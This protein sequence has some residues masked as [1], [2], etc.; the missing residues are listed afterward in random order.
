[1][2]NDLPAQGSAPLNLASGAPSHGELVP[3]G[4]AAAIDQ[5]VV[6]IERAVATQAAK[7]GTALRMPR[8]RNWRY[9]SE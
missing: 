3:E 6:A 9:G 1:M 7:D 4:E 2:V 5:I 8:R